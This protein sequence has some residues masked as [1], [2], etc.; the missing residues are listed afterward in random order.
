MFLLTVLRSE[1]GIKLH[2]LPSIRR[3]IDFSLSETK[4]IEIRFLNF[5]IGSNYELLM[6]VLV[7]IFTVSQWIPKRY[8]L[9]KSGH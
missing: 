1:K 8:T 5:F 4:I 6:H 2:D 9:Y 3:V 7:N